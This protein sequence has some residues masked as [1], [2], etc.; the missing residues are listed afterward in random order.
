MLVPCI[1]SVFYNV[2]HTLL[3][4]GFSKGTLAVQSYSSVLD[5]VCPKVKN[6]LVFVFCRPLM[7]TFWCLT[8]TA[9][10]GHVGTSNQAVLTWVDIRGPLPILVHALCRLGLADVNPHQH[11]VPTWPRNAVFVDAGVVKP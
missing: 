5:V 3:N 7:P 1:W 11:I 10:R 8:F 9:F 4:S 2:S 6:K